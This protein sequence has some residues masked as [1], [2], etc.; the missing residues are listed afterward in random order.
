MGEATPTLVAEGKALMEAYGALNRNDIA[1][2]VKLFDREVERI[3][4]AEFPMDG[5]YRGLD[6]VKANLT[7]GRESWAEGGCEAEQFIVAGDRV[8]VLVYVRVRLKHETEWRMGAIADVFTFRD[9]KVVQMRTFGD[10][11]EA[12][13]WAG[14]QV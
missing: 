9:G 13:E 6:A 11:R 14:A 1:G 12:L 3:E 10:R 8:V 7:R 2:F 5:T 4:P